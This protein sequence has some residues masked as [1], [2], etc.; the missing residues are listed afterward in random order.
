MTVYP[1][2][3]LSV[4]AKNAAKFIFLIGS[5][6]LIIEVIFLFIVLRKNV[7]QP[8][9]RFV[10]ASEGVSEGKYK[11][12]DYHLPVQQKNEIGVLARTFLHMSNNIHDYQ[13]NLE[14]KI[15]DR[16][17]E[18]EDLKEKAEELARTDPLTNLP[19]RRAFFEVGELELEEAKR[20]GHDLTLIMLDID[21]FK[22]I[23]DTYG[24]ATGDEVLKTIA[25][26]LQVTI[27]SSDTA[28]RIGGEEFAILLSHTNIED[29]QSTA[30]KLRERM[31]ALALKV[32]DTE[33]IFTASFGVAKFTGHD[34]TLDTLVANADKA[35]YKA[36]EAG[37]NCVIVDA[38]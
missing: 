36:K 23:N 30:E 13:V 2:E 18:L 20:Y 14:N 37:R 21:L 16:T 28:A 34:Q 15:N 11:L 7:I 17:K 26:L 12:N 10:T 25:L 5:L 33:V 9:R 38:V 29:A 6:G 32:A 8:L 3:L 35:L 19:N 22:N 31:Q 27:R 4:P 1:K 24:H